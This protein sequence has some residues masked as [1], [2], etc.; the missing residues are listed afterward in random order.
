VHNEGEAYPID[1]LLDGQS[2]FHDGDINLVVLVPSIR[3]RCGLLVF[4][5]VLENKVLTDENS[6]KADATEHALMI[7]NGTV[8]LGLYF[9]FQMKDPAAS[10]AEEA[11]KTIALTVMRFV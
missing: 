5:L 3:L 2:S 6:V 10:P 7:E 9:V 4:H 11:I 1:F 8:F